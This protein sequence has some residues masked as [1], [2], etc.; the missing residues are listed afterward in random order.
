MMP[1]HYLAC[2]LG[3][4]SGRLMLGTLDQGRLSL[5]ELHRFANGAQEENGSLVWDIQHLLRELYRGLSCAAKQDLT[6]D[7]ISTD[8]WGVDYV[9]L[10]ENSKII[11]P[12]YCYRDPRMEQGVKKVL[13]QV[14]WPSLF[15]ETGIQFM[16]INTIFQLAAEPQERLQKARAILGI[17]DAF[18]FFLS[19]KP[20][21]EQSLASTTQLYNPRTHRW[22]QALLDTLQF[23]ASLFPP[24]VPSGTRLGQ[25]RPEIVSE[26]GLGSNT[27]VIATCSHD[28]GAAVAAVP[29]QGDSWAYLSSGTWSLMGI[30]CAQPVINDT[31]RDLNFTNE[32]G[33]DRTVRLLKNIVGLWMI[34]ECRRE[35]AAGGQNYDYETL[36]KLAA[37]AEP[38][39][40]ILNCADQRFVGAGQMPQKIA[41]F[42]RETNQPPPQSPGDFTRCILESLALLYAH[43][44][45]KLEILK[46]SKIERL[47]IVGGGSRN[48]LLNQFTANAT[49]RR[50]VAGPAE[51]TALGNV[52]VQAITMG[53][54][55]HLTEGRKI[56]RDSSSLEMFEPADTAPWRKALAELERLLA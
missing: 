51:A 49:G 44:L 54:I 36:T 1:N 15:A 53:H 56:V 12:T 46:G 38:F 40:A 35:W 27:Q 4:E 52:L 55:T 50:I 37:E 9:L 24:V 28:T 6:V 16:P 19:G 31:C 22:S 13:R 42:C 32:I 41:E 21:A 7:S 29:A 45:K 8:S 26:T 30:E 17:G 14:D 2:D 25:V 48:R 18:N 47:H 5:Q 20:W 10:D 43:T 39:S 34:Q 23:P 11:P 3:A 33:H